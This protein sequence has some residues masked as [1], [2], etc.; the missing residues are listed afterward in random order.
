LLQGTE[1]RLLI[2][3]CSNEWAE[4]LIEWAEKLIKKN[5]KTW[6]DWTS[7]DRGGE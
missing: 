3:L 1:K 5:K 4:K 7:P 2:S 6:M